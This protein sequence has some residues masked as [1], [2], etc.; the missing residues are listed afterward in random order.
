MSFYLLSPRPDVAHVIISLTKTVN[1]EQTYAQINYLSVMTSVVQGSTAGG[2]CETVQ[3]FTK[4]TS[5]APQRDCR[6][7][8]RLPVELS[9][10]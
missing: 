2:G 3:Y 1:D 4:V 7:G 5:D 8:E 6:K 9:D 10:L